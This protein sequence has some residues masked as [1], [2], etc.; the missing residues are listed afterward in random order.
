MIV[1]GVR[2]L[3]TINMGNTRT[4]ALLYSHQEKH[5]RYVVPTKADQDHYREFFRQIPKPERILLSSVVPKAAAELHAAALEVWG[6][7]VEQIHARE[8]LGI[9]FAGVDYREL[10]SDLFV[11]AVAS[12]HLFGGNI[13][14]VDLGSASTFC[15][16]KQGVYL[17]TSIVP[18]M[19]ISIRAMIQGT[20]LLRHFELRKTE[21]II[22][23]DTI[24]CLQ[25]GTFYGYFEL[26]RGMINRIQEEH[27]AL[28]VVL[29]GGIGNFLH[30]ELTP[31][32][33]HFLPDLTLD[34][35][36]MIAEMSPAV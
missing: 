36:S 11:N 5:E 21:R 19:E 35:L 3:L 26:V 31:Y 32:V 29:T 25:S 30:D 33:H 20:A 12:H 16:V 4:K 1:G 27:G 23:T 24:S 14:N 8:D 18:G 15:V 6:L 34:G 7:R 10:G 9:T 28:T 2:V 13:L 17:G 22:N